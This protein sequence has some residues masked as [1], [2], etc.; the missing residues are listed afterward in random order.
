MTKR[1]MLNEMGLDKFLM[2]IQDLRDDECI[3]S[4]LPGGRL[5]CPWHNDCRRCLEDWLNEEI[6]EN[7]KE[8]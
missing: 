7:E 5:I 1:D 2:Y 8:D 4:L 3:M 6:P